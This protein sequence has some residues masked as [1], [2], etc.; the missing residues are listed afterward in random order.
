MKYNL[1]GNTGVYAS[2]LCLGGMTF[3]AKTQLRDDLAPLGETMR[4]LEDA[5]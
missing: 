3:G 1:L 2:E 4:G 5:G